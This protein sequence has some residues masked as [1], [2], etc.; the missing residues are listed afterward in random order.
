MHS[1]LS[2]LNRNINISLNRVSPIFR[3]VRKIVKSDYKLRH[4][5]PHG[6]TRLP[7]DGLSWNFIFE[8]FFQ[9]LSRKFT[10]DWNLRSTR[11]N[12]YFTWRPMY[13]SCRKTRNTHFMFSNVFFF[14]GNRS[15]CE[16][17]WK[18]TVERGRPQMTIRRKRIACGITKAT[19][20]H[21]HTQNM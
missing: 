6:T 10:F 15:V 11:Y 16:I 4:V 13:K 3:R 9:N 1:R 20:T 17:T 21:T 14:S 18:N 8:Y 19:D 5:R 12:G 7:L 2:L